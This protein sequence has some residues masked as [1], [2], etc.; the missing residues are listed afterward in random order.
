MCTGC[1]SPQNVC[2]W[3]LKEFR[4]Q[5]QIV[6]GECLARSKDLLKNLHPQK[7]SK[8]RRAKFRKERKSRKKWTTISNAAGANNGLQRRAV[9]VLELKRPRCSGRK[10]ISLIQ[11]FS[12]GRRNVVFG[13]F[14]RF[15]NGEKRIFHHFVIHQ[16]IKKPNF[17]DELQSAKNVHFW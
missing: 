15:Q 9:L 14:G 6:S 16:K 7:K 17:G 13:V 8:Q 12:S 11:Q 1:L 10:K 5:K 3:G 4:S 2:G